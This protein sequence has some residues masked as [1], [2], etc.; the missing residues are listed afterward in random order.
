MAASWLGHFDIIWWMALF[1]LESFSFAILIGTILGFLSG[2]GTGGGSLLILWLTLG[3]GMAQEKARLIN[4]M[5]FIPSALVACIFRW[6]QG[7]LDIKKI[8]PAIVAG[9]ISAGMFS[10]LGSMMETSLLRKLF[11]GLLLFTGIREILYRPKK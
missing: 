3:V 7:N 10:I 2:L 9:S 11:G 4:L 1:M 6:K 8:L 5:F